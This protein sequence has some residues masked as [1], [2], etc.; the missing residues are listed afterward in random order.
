MCAYRSS[1]LNP[2]A[3]D[4][5]N[6]QAVSWLIMAT[7]LFAGLAACAGPSLQEQER[8]IRVNDLTLQELAPR[9]FINVWGLPPYHHAEF[10]Q[11]FEL[12]D[13]A[14]IPHWRVPAGENP[15]GWDMGLAAG[16]A[17]Y[18]AYPDQGWLLV[19]VDDRLVYRE[20]IRAEELHTL[21]RTWKREQQFKTT[22]ERF[23]PQ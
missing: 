18:L 8:R 16:Q 6:V 17:L 3:G 19:F 10:T 20:A 9:A 5:S 13:G 23:S 14:L 15:R 2:R 11:F 7:L 21:G 4:C 12:Q 22:I 1:R